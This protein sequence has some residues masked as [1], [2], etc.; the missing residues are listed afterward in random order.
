MFQGRIP[1]VLSL[2]LCVSPPA[3]PRG[4]LHSHR[5]VNPSQTGGGG[6]VGKLSV[7][8]SSALRGHLHSHRYVNPCQTWG[9]GV[10]KLS[11]SPPAPHSHL[12]SHRYVNPSQ[13]GDGEGDFMCCLLLLLVTTYI[14]I[15]C[16]LIIILDP[17]KLSINIIIILLLL[18]LFI[19]NIIVG[20]FKRSV[21]EISSVLIL[22]FFVYI[23]PYQQSSPS[24]GRVR[25][26]K[27]FDWINKSD[28][29]LLAN[30]CLV[31]VLSTS[32]DDSASKDTRDGGDGNCQC[33]SVRAVICTVGC[34][35][36]RYASTVAGAP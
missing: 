14:P 24:R 4:H 2:L 35:W 12:H 11:V 25:K 3:A 30:L 5:Y 29:V 19:I 6:G 33:A 16:I 13:T 18:L 8:P 28:T 9:V 23:K 17:S 27:C 20:P 1:L 22:L 15:I 10:G 36:T 31:A 7:S 26:V 21:L 32:Y 34:D